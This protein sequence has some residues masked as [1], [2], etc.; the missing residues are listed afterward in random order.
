MVRAAARACS[1][2]DGRLGEAPGDDH[3]GFGG[4]AAGGAP[5]TPRRRFGH[6]APAARTQPNIGKGETFQISCQN[7]VR[8]YIVGK[9]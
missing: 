6:G 5:N 8:T 3:G 4:S 9:I 7:L 1:D 2:N